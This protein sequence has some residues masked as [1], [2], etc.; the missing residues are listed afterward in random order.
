MILDGIKEAIEELEN[1][2]GAGN[3]L[4]ARAETKA[5]GF[6]FLRRRK[7]P[8][9]TRLFL[10]KRDEHSERLVL[11]VELTSAYYVEWEDVRG[12]MQFMYASLAAGFADQITRASFLAYGVPDSDGEIEVYAIDPDR[13]DVVPPSGTEPF[14]KVFAAKDV[15]ERFIVPV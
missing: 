3:D 4:T 12:Q 15:Q 2:F 1:G 8:P 14:W 13:R 10:L 6:D 7:F 5:A 9:A 11:I